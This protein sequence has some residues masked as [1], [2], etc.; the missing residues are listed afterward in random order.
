[1]SNDETLL[2]YQKPAHKSRPGKT[3]REASENPEW[4]STLAKYGWEN[5]Y[6]SRDSSEFLDSERKELAAEFA[7]LGVVEAMTLAGRS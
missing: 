7:A 4:K 5:E 1:M 6:M 2:R 3:I